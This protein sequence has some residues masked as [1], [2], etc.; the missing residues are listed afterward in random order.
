L[1]VVPD[2]G[3]A[4]ILC[5]MLR[6]EGIRCAHYR[7]NTSSGGADAS[8]SSGGWREIVVLEDDLERASA[9]LPAAESGTV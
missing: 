9:L 7:T 1:T 5:G 4:D 8:T 3:E 2:E 6:A